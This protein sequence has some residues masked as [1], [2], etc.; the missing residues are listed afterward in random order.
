MPTYDFECKNP[1]CGDSFTK[2]LLIREMNVP[3]E[4][5]CGVCGETK[6]ERV[7]SGTRI[8]SG[9]NLASKVPSGFR[10]V[11]NRVRKEHPHGKIEGE[12]C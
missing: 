7:I 12:L 1:E 5:P 6:V 2:V 8:V 4:T 10:E 11:L 9:V 3:C